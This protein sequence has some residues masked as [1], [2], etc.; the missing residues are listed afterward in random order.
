MNLK[1][2]SILAVGCSKRFMTVN[3]DGHHVTIRIPISVYVYL[4]DNGCLTC[5][6]A[7]WLRQKNLK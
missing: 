5:Q 3:L 2:I 4:R 1:V 7:R 6:K